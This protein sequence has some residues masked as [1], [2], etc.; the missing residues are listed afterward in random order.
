[1]K[2]SYQKVLSDSRDFKLEI[3]VHNNRVVGDDVIG[4]GIWRETINMTGCDLPFVAEGRYS[5]VMAKRNGKWVIILILSSIPYSPKIIH[6]F[7]FKQKI[8]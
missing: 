2:A 6:L 4:F 1:M 5:D 3:T 7:R 8:C